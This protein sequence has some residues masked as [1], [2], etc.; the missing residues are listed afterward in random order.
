MFFE[1]FI[2]SC[3]QRENEL[4]WFC[5]KSFHLKSVDY[6]IGIDWHQSQ[7]KEK[8][9]EVQIPPKSEKTHTQMYTNNK[10]LLFI[11]IIFILKK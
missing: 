7:V 2:L 6:S 4:P 11:I 8:L 3:Y 5:F 1:L 10:N 9:F